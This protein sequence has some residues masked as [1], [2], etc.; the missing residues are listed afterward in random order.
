MWHVATLV[1]Q[2]EC[3]VCYLQR[4]FAIA[5]LRHDVLYCNPRVVG[6]HSIDGGIETVVA[7]IGVEFLHDNLVFVVTLDA[8]QLV[9]L[10]LQQDEKTLVC[11]ILIG[12]PKDNFER[13][14]GIVAILEGVCHVLHLS[15]RTFVGVL[16]F[17]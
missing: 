3:A 11:A 1:Q 16:V 12:H 7:Q 8:L 14:V 2:D 17:G 5:N 13:F 6:R 4:V 15:F 10:V 9:L